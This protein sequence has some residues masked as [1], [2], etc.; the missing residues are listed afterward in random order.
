VHH[1]LGLRDRNLQV[2]RLR[3]GLLCG[4]VQSCEDGFYWKTDGTFRGGFAL[5]NADGSPRTSATSLAIAYGSTACIVASDATVW[6]QGSNSYG[7]LGNGDVTI[8][9]S[10]KLVQVLKGAAPSGVPLAGIKKVSSGGNYYSFCALA[11]DG[12]VWCWGQGT[13][14]E[15]GTGSKLNS[16]FAVSVLDAAGASPI[17]GVTDLAVGA[18][19]ACVL[20]ADGTVW[21]WG[22][23]YYG[24]LGTGAAANGA[25]YPS[26]ANVPAITEPVVSIFASS[27]GMFRTTCA[28]DSKKSV[29]CWGNQAGPD[30]ASGNNLA[31]IRLAMS[32]NGAAFTDAVQVDA[33]RKSDGTLWQ[34]DATSVTPVTEN[35]IPV[36]GS[37]YLGRGCWIGSDGQLRGITT[38]VTCP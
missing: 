8:T 3:L 17:S 38:T 13:T 37:F 19:Y 5:T 28:V 15:L 16:S 1:R 7:Q 21:C 26:P 22:Y 23:N 11:N 4:C 36:A 32:K 12:G 35:S 14:G 31:P 34:W 29:W 24:E 33:I 30:G 20:K 25:I 9:S 18:S 2:R 6:C 10:S 27:S